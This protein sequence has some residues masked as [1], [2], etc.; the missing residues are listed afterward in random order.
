[1]S[2]YVVEP[3]PITK[4]SIDLLRSGGCHKDNGSS[5]HL[6]SISQTDHS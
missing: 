5:D 4:L 1:M 3:F 6:G 2:L